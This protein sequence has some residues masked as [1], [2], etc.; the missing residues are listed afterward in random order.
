MTSSALP[1]SRRQDM[2]R[3]PRG[4]KIQIDENTTEAERTAVADLIEATEVPRL[5]FSA[6]ISPSGTDGWRVDGRVTATVVQPCVVTLAPVVTRIDAPFTRHYQPD[7]EDAPVEGEVEIDSAQED[8][9][10]LER[11]IDIGGAAV[12]ALSLALPPYPRA[13]GAELPEIARDDA[14]GDADEDRPNPFAALAALRG[15]DT[16]DS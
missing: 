3:A 9:E 7:V 12:E 13:E 2:F 4:K 6:R 15:K 11:F 10:P 1:V 8:I 5:R 16:P 14:G